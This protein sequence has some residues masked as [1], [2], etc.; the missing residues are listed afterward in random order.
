MKIFFRKLTKI[1]FIFLLIVQCSCVG[2]IASM[3][4]V[5]VEKYGKKVKEINQERV[6]PKDIANEII[7]S[8]PPSKEEISDYISSQEKYQGYVPIYS[9]GEYVPKQYLPDRTTYNEFSKN[10]PSN[11]VAPDIFEISYNTQAHPPFSYSGAEFDMISVPSTDAYGNSTKIS[12]KKYL[13]IANSDIQNTV[14]KINQKRSN[15]D[16]EFSKILI[17]EKKQLIKKRKNDQ[18]FGN[19]GF[20]DIALIDNIVNNELV[21]EVQDINK[22][23]VK[24]N[25]S[26]VNN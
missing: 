14:T 17:S 25:T 22:N 18:I 8:T 11:N 20:G 24:L 26:K 19:S 16:G 12:E 9:V 13:L 10:N 23:I 21:N 7:S 15:N 2:D 1:K 5:F 3:N 4:D 6:L